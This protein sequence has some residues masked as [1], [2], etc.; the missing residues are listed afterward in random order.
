VRLAGEGADIIAVDIGRNVEDVP[1]AM[2]TTDEMAETVGQ[3]E[4][5]GRRIVAKQADTRDLDGLRAAVD[6]GV[7]ELGRLDVVVANAGIFTMQTW[8]ETT[9]EIWQRTLDVNLTGTWHTC[10]VSIPHL[11]TAGGGSIIIINSVAGLK[12]LPFMIPYNAAKAGQLGI[13]R[14]LSTELGSHNIRVNTVHPG[15]VETPMNLGMAHKL[16]L[17]EED[18]KAM[19]FV[20]TSL[21]DP[22]MQPIEVS[23]A[24]LYLASDESRMVTGSMLPVDGGMLAR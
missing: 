23:H 1:T 12:G 18:P 24:V 6:A 7:E 10:F 16:G 8:D 9:P 2:G 20:M 11:I 21:P 17:Y 19:A 4:A 3:V 15:N 14:A 13:M 22:V 5:L